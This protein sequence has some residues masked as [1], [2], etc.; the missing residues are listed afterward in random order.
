MDF[1]RGIWSAALNGEVEQV[2]KY[3]DRKCSPDILDSAG[4]TALVNILA[5]LQRCQI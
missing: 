1:T 4:Y 3:L 5:A 2:K